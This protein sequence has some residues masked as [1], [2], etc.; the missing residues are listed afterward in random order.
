MTYI[1]ARVGAVVALT[2]EDY[3]AQKTLVAS[4]PREKWQTF[5]NAASCKAGF[6][7]SVETRA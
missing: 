4:P 5:F 1:S 2:V 7:S 3:Y 6:W